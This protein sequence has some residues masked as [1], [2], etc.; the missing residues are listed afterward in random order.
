MIIEHRKNTIVALNECRAALD[1]IAAVIICDVAEFAD[2]C[3]MD[4]AAEDGIHMVAFRIMRHSSF[5]F[6]NK[7]H[8][9]LHTPLG[10]SAE[11]PVSETEAA[12]DKVNKRIERE[13]KLVAKIARERE[14]FHVLHHGIEFVTMDHQNSFPA[15]GDMDCPLLNLDVAVG[16]TEVRHHLVVIA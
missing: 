14:P 13:Q 8:C 10:I 16:A 12:P 2:G 4:V 7:A 15:S 9:V 1:P 11:R 5:E 6:A 3:A